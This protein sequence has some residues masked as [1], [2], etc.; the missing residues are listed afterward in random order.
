MKIK[1][2]CENENVNLLCLFFLTYLVLKFQI[3]YL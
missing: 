1:I 2:F 3:Q